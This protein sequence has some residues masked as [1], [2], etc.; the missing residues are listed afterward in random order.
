MLAGVAAFTRSGGQAHGGAGQ[1]KREATEL[2][3]RLAE[4]SDIW[5][6][7]HITYTNP[8]IGVS[9]FRFCTPHTPPAI[10]LPYLI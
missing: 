10:A 1:V 2:L 4:S 7:Y 5:M 3:N 8:P 6:T 9:P